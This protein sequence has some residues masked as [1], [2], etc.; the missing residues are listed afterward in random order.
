MI[1]QT[2]EY[3]L[4]ATLHLAE[5]LDEIQTIPTIAE[6][7]EVP[8]GYLSKVMQTLRRAGLVTSR[9]GKNGGFRLRREPG[10]ITLYDVV[11]AV[12][13]MVQVEQCPLT[14]DA[15]CPRY[16]FEFGNHEHS[17]CPLHAV[18]QSM[19]AQV[20]R[21]FRSLSLADCLKGHE[22]LLTS[23]SPAGPFELTGPWV[24]GGK[25]RGT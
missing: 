14:L 19:S 21:Q 20:E 4:R 15:K 13:P 12:D 7:T 17:L 8:A 9:R 22:G 1:S 24:A 3:A 6:A 2:A 25:K 11:N 18:L 16:G 10:R 5:R 23:S